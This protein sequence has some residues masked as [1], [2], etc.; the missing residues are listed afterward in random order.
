MAAESRIVVHQL[1]DGL[2][3]HDRWILEQ[4]FFRRRSQP[5]IAA[6][7]GISQSYLS[8]VIHRILERLRDQLNEP[9]GG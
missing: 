1:I 4:R 7:L 2:D 6:Q 8:R 9:A 5:D 3:A